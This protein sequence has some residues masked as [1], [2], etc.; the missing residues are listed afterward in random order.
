M[1][2]HPTIQPVTPKRIPRDMVLGF[3]ACHPDLRSRNG[4]RWA[5]PGQWT[6]AEG[7]FRDH[8][9]SCPNGEG[10][11]VCIART[12]S[13]A[14]SGGI[15]GG[16]YLLV[17]YAPADVLGEDT[18][19]VRV[20]RALTLDVFT[21]TAFI[22]PGA[23]LGGANLWG[24][25]LGGADLGGA[26]LGGANLRGADLWGANLGGAD[27]WD[28][29]L[30]GAN[31]RGANL[32]GADLW[33][34]NLGG[35]DLGGADLGGANLRGANLRGANL[36]GADLW[37]ANLGGADLLGADA[38]ERTVVPSGWVVANGRIEKAQ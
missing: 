16:T 32:G 4:F 25:D 1:I 28:A 6:H 38:N 27:L 23:D 30:R 19:K 13:G 26:D 15:P 36:R 5:F 33:G 12:L 35:A 24:A 2:L 20:K 8:G 21:F 10:D 29:N 31:L 22:G 9:G 17:A 14:A 11:G 3:R 7:P 37:D 18:H 34:A